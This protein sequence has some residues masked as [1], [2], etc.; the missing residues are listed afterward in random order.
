[1][2]FFSRRLDRLT[3]IARRN[4]RA[5]SVTHPF[6]LP[7]REFTMRVSAIVGEVLR[8]T[9][10]LR[11]S[12][13]FHADS[14]LFHADLADSRREHVASSVLAIWMASNP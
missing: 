11:E 5:S 1:M 4:S 7:P 3:Q 13:C 14:F 6:G 2:F 12:T 9:K 8:A 10:M